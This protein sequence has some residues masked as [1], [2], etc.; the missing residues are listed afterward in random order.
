MRN[1]ILAAVAAAVLA[2]GAAAPAEAQRVSGEVSIRIGDRNDYQYR[3]YRR[4][5]RCYA[6]EVLVRDVY[7]GRR[8]CMSQREY[9][10]YLRNQRRDYYRY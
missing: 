10:R 5:R 7:S 3:D 2:T 8:Y 1:S 9:H 6:N 4:Y